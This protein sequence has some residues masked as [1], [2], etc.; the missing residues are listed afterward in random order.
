MPG[1]KCRTVA[2]L[3]L[4]VYTGG[5]KDVRTILAAAYQYGDKLY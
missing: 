2:H 5:L 4:L 3:A 1:S